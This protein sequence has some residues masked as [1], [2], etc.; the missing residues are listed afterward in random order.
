MGEAGMT[1]TSRTL[2]S[3]RP[4]AQRLE[5]SVILL[6]ARDLRRDFGAVRAVNGVSFD[7]HD[8]EVL[9]IIGPNGSGKTSTINLLTGLLRP[10]AGTIEL[11]GRRIDRLSTERIAEL[12]VRRTFQNGRVFAGMTVAENVYVGLYSQLTA[13]RPLS[14]LRHLP[15]LRWIPLLAELVLALVPPP[16]V[17][18]ENAATER[19]IDEQLARFDQRLAPRRAHPAY[20]LSYA[21]RRRT[22]I[23]RALVSKPAV[24]LLDEPTAGM[25]QTETAE[26]L[27]QLLELKAQ[28]QAM[29]LVEHKIDLVMKLSDRVIVMD[30]G[31]VI[32]DGTPDEVRGNERVIEAYLGRRREQPTAAPAGQEGR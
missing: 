31:T 5:P 23:A 13:S 6:Q 10:D 3:M 12:G 4:D 15:V 25:N 28:G 21:N 22:E 32:A 24:L 30:N 27:A 1:S 8:N 26:V 9:S 14:R 2:V 16:R 18:R 7:L 17:R 11:R 20:T 19:E 29:L